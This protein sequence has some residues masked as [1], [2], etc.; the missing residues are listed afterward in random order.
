L[1]SSKII[2]LNNRWASLLKEKVK[3]KRRFYSV[4]A[5]FEKVD[6]NLPT[7]ATNI[8]SIDPRHWIAG[9]VVVVWADNGEIDVNQ[10]Q[11][12]C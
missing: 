11:G 6:R 8:S 9:Y 10:A 2:K 5:L 12:I 3:T 7:N 4:E 1:N